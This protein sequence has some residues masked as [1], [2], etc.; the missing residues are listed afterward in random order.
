MNLK[1]LEPTE[2]DRYNLQQWLEEIYFDDEKTPHLTHED[3]MQL[4]L[5]LRKMLRF[6]PS[7]RYAALE[8]LK[9][10]WFLGSG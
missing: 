8:I 9:D 5:T 7:E 4:S 2:E 3:I 6:D 1:S 10:D